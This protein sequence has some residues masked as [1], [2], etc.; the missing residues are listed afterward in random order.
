[1]TTLPETR[2]DSGRVRGLWRLHRGADGS[3]TRHAIFLGVPFAAPPVGEVRFDAPR[4]VAAWSGVRD[5]FLHGA[6]SQLRSPWDPPRIPE[7]SIAG[8]ATLNVNVTTPNPAR[9][10]R[11]PVL[12]W[13]HGGGFISGSPASPWYGGQG[14][15]RDGVVTVTISYRVGFEGFGWMAD[16]VNNRGVLDWLAA[17]EWVQRNV[18]AFGGDPSRVTIGGQ[19]A[20]GAAVMRL[21]TMRSAQHL[22]HSVLAISPPDASATMAEGRAASARIAASVG[23]SPDRAS[24][25][26]VDGLT[27]FEARDAALAPV[28][29]V[30]TGFVVR[31]A[32]SLALGPLVDGDVCETSVTDALAEGVGAGKS[33]FLGACAH[34]FNEATANLAHLI[35]DSPAAVILERAG[36][37]TA[38]A[39]EMAEEAGDKGA[40]WALGQGMTD[41]I[42]R[43]TVAHWAALRVAHGAPTWVYDFRWES[44]APGVNG[45]AHCVDVPFGMDILGFPATDAAIG[46]AAPQALADAVHG[47]WLA[48]VRDGAVDAPRF[49]EDREVVVYG[50]DASRSV[51]TGYAREARLWDATRH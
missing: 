37:P 23:A 40:A 50:A 44:R 8:P 20:G 1:M 21:L 10:A 31:E 29:D 22:F 19:S 7:P 30:L 33:V 36:V 27:L 2:I 41:A 18:E 3:V 32:Q 49:G 47:D 14:F 4:A 13:I 34:E 15:A 24:L 48:L 6:T 38:I 16:A 25:E 28:D 17:L 11:M 46:P 9:G 43:Q 42:F 39:A 5:C 51:G 26:A 45:A 12:V 35:G